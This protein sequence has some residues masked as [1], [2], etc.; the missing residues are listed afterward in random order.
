MVVLKVG[1]FV[2]HRTNIRYVTLFVDF[3]DRR[4]MVV[5]KAGN[6]VTHRTNIRHVIP[7]FDS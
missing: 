5:G 3:V 1:N 6:C 4:W 7:F 2:T